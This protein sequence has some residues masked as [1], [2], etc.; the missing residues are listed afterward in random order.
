MRL[1]LVIVG[2]FFLFNPTINVVDPLPDFIGYFFILV[3]LT[4][5]STLVDK[6]AEARKLFTRL[7]LVTAIKIISAMFLF[8]ADDTLTLVLVFS[9]AIIELMCIF[10]AYDRFFDGL[11]YAGTRYN[12]TAVFD[13]KTKCTRITAEKAKALALSG[14]SGIIEETDADGTKTYYREKTVDRASSLKVYTLVFMT[15]KLALSV[16]P[17][18]PAL[19]L[20]DHIGSVSQIS[21]DYSKFKPMF[22]V[23]VWVLTLAAGIPWLVKMTSYLI[24]VLRD[25][26]FIDSMKTKYTVEVAPDKTRRIVS[27]MSMLLS[28]LSVGV[29]ATFDFYI[30]HINVTPDFLAAVFMIAVFVILSKNNKA[31]ISGVLSSVAW[32]TASAVNLWRQ[33]V[34]FNKYSSNMIYMN[35]I[36]CELYEK[37]E[38]SM[39]IESVF[40]TVTYILLAVF[41]IKTINK[42]IDCIGIDKVGY[43]VGNNKEIRRCVSSRMITIAI[44]AGVSAVVYAVYPFIATEYEYALPIV[45]GVQIVMVAYSLFSL[46]TIN[47]E[48]YKRLRGD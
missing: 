10:P 3:G 46:M 9:F 25:E 26:P 23:V 6:L 16:V 39:I 20:Y 42:H 34:F 35:V 31:A 15:L 7:C 14:T 33:I 8:F 12:G 18:L 38:L 29:I 5:I 32:G 1:T 4:R 21:V 47:D 19:Q 2:M 17:E 43:T 44:L 11:L 36:A 22:L 30:D 37:L 41:M 40:G 28:L 45:A 13:S 27:T 24:S 48:V